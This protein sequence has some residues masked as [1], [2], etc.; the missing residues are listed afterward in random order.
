M[1]DAKEDSLTAC[2]RCRPD[3][4]IFGSYIKMTEAQKKWIEDHDGMT[5]DEAAQEIAT[6]FKDQAFLT[7]WR[8][9]T[10]QGHAEAKEKMNKLYR[11]KSGQSA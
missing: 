8:N 7:R 6:L 1:E 4:T 2:T 11:I 9:P 10:S 5:P 3:D